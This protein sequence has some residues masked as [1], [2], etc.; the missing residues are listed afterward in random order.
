MRSK[1]LAIAIWQLETSETSEVQFLN[2]FS[3]LLETFYDSAVSDGRWGWT[4]TIE[5][6]RSILQ[7]MT[8]ALWVFYEKCYMTNTHDDDNNTEHKHMHK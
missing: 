6:E 3:S 4:E 5:M 1:N 2:E 7:C 8:D